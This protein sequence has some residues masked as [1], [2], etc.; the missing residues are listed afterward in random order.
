MIDDNDNVVQRWWWWWTSLGPEGWSSLSGR[1]DEGGDDGDNWG[2]DGDDWGDDG[3]DC[4]DNGERDGGNCVDNNS[5]IGDGGKPI[6][7]RNSFSWA[8]RTWWVSFFLY[9]CTRKG[10]ICSWFIGSC[11]CWWWQSIQIAILKDDSRLWALHAQSFWWLSLW[12][13]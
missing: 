2:D 11:W 1:R 4:G 13:T 6:G 3:D 7:Q 5:F 12:L 8:G 10:R 9:N